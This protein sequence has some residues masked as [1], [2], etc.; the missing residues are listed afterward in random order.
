MA[1][2][3][4]VA[5][6]TVPRRRRRKPVCNTSGIIVQGPH[7]RGATATSSI[8]IQ[9]AKESAMSNGFSES[10]VWPFRQH[11]QTFGFARHR[12]GT[13]RQQVATPVDESNI[14]T[15]NVGG[16]YATKINSRA[17]PILR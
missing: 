1:K 8:G 15:T 5:T 16:K 2:A 17:L 14:V 11:G 10:D 12:P 3:S 6:L 13:F 7:A 9:K 4:T